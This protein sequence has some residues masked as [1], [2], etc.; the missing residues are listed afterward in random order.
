[1]RFFN[2]VWAEGT[3]PRSWKQATVVPILKPGKEPNAPTSYRPIALTSCVGKVFERMVNHRL[4]Y[5]LT[6]SGIL[7]E[8]QCGFRQGYSTLDHLARLETVIRESFVRRQ[9]C[10]SIFFD[11]EKAYDTTWRYGILQ[12]LYSYGIRGRMLKL[13][14]NF[15]RDRFFRV[16]VGT[17]YSR[18]FQQENGVPQ[19]SVLSVTLFIVKMNSIAKA[20]PRTIFYSLYVDDVQ[21]S[22]S[23]SSLPVAERQLQIATNK[24]SAWATQNGFK[25][26]PQKTACVVFSRRRGLYPDPE[27]QLDGHLIDVRP[28]QKFLGVIFDRKLT[29]SPD[30]KY[31]RKKDLKALNIL[32]VLSHK[33]W[34]ADRETMLKVYKSVVRS[35]LEYGC[36]VYGSACLSTLKVLD[37]VHHAGLR[38]ALGAFR[39]SPVE[40][41]YVE[42][43]E[44]SL[45]R[46]RQYLTALHVIR[47]K[48]FPETPSH[49]CVQVIRH[50]QL[51]ANKPSV[52]PPL[53]IRSQ[54]ILQYYHIAR[55]RN[56]VMQV[57]A[58]PAPWELVKPVCD[59]SLRQWDKRSTP[60]LVLQQEF[61]ALRE[62]FGQ[63]QAFYTDGTKSSSGVGC[64]VITNTRS[65][66]VRLPDS[67]S[68]FTAEL[69]AIKH[70]V[71]YINIKR[72]TSPVI[73]TDSMSSLHAISSN[74]TR[75]PLVRQIRNIITSV[76]RNGSDLKFV[77]VPSHVGITGNESADRAA[78]DSLSNREGPY[79]I[80]YQDLTPLVRRAFLRKWQSF[81]DTQ[82]KNKL[83]LVKPQIGRSPST[84]H[85][86]RLREVTLAR[87]RIGHTYMTHG[88]LLRSE[89]PP[90]CPRCGCQLSVVHILLECPAFQSRREQCFRYL[91]EHRIPLHPSLILGDESLIDF[92]RVMKF[93]STVGILS[94]I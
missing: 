48:A 77:W 7:D 71:H 78:A 16:R 84:T 6:Q 74:T 35:K 17:T 11:L 32:K 45:E 54:K 12:D 13:I 51:F 61:E 33:S 40:S 91:C 34:G 38:L 85:V 25:F 4:V 8:N 72:I 94:M 82:T 59:F 79:E 75:N 24:I 5:F 62:S 22:Y 36:V 3:L 90:D 28:E 2:K 41:L 92:K 87:L 49:R 43:G 52:I 19:G 86:D 18:L 80:P 69:Y 44:P 55:H 56:L 63:H 23:S 65:I 1:M 67:A 57:G 53:N 89:N 39:T 58:D 50:E 10:V 83:H 66:K 37:T 93:I 76:H 46:R 73:Y 60:H 68:V 27:I 26:S 64:A 9:H 70:A 15:L 30:V 31:I 21:I 20:I 47:N 29:F 42:S 14:Q 88:F 81:W